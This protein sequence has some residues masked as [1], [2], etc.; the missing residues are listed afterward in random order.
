M[1]SDVVGGDFHPPQG[2]VADTLDIDRVRSSPP[3]TLS[4]VELLS[5]NQTRTQ[6]NRRMFG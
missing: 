6:T 2:V 1:S 4:T 5:M 3:P